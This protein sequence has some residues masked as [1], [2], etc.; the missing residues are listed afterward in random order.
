MTDETRPPRCGHE[1]KTGPCIRP[2]GHTPNGHQSRAARDKQEAARKQKAPPPA[3]R[4]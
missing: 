3:A 4:T 1:T 2:E